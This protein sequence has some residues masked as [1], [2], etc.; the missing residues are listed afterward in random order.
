MPREITPEYTSLCRRCDQAGLRI[1]LYVWRD[2]TDPPVWVVSV[3]DHEHTRLSSWAQAKEL[4]D[5]LP[6][7]SKALLE[8]L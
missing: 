7:L 1:E 4:N 2:E 8:Q 5:V 3:R 6:A